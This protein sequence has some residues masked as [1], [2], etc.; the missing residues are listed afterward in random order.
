MDKPGSFSIKEMNLKKKKIDHSYPYYRVNRIAPRSAL[1]KS[2]RG[3]LNSRRWRIR[4]KASIKSPIARIVLFLFLLIFIVACGGQTTEDETPVEEGTTAEETDSAG[5]TDAPEEVAPADEAVSIEFW[6]PAGRGRD[7]GTAA[8]VEAFEAQYPNIQVEVSAIPFGEFANSLKVAYAGDSPPDAALVN[9]VEIQNLA[10]NGALLPIDDIFTAEDKDDF[11]TDLI[12]MVTYD[13]Q[14]YGAPWAQA[15][16]AMYYNIDLFAA[17]GVEAPQTLD[18][19]WTWAE[20]KENVQAVVDRQAEDDN[21]IWGIIGLNSPIQGGFFAWTM[22]RSNSEP[23]SPLW[24]TISP[25]FTTVSGY[26]DT[27]EAMEAYEFFQGLYIDGLAPRDDIP[28]AFG[29]GQ[30]ATFMAI[31]P[32]G[33]TLNR[34]FPDLNWGV[35]P[36]PYHK[37]PLTHTG[38]FAPA[39]SVKSDEQEAAKLFV[40]FFTSSEGYQVYHSVTPVIPARKSLQAELPELQEG[41]LAFLFEEAI[42][43]G[44]ARPGGPAHSILDGII[45]RDMMINIAL[46]ADISEAVEAAIAE[47]DAQ[48]TQ[49]R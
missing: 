19:G 16:V 47:T 2:C 42:E 5:E 3:L 13:G 9:G 8:V 43:W 37:T 10:F 29:N 18:D 48:L 49:F 46:G 31:P 39:V 44:E 36:I 17:A 41:Y 12:D 45:N 40:A 38:S 28:D 22:V 15:A 23:G 34:N 14:M 25:D 27:P 4:M 26:I 6:I 11:M 33:S 21:E 1:K 35:M 30:A 24:D 7:E 32:T 20:Y